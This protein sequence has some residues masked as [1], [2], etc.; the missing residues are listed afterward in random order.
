MKYK[1]AIVKI[2][3]GPDPPKRVD[4]DDW[5][6]ESLD[7]CSC[8]R[9]GTCTTGDN[10]IVTAILNIHKEHRHFSDYTKHLQ[11][12]IMEQFPTTPMVIFMQKGYGDMVAAQHPGGAK[13]KYLCLVEM[14]LE[15]LPE[16]AFVKDW[17][18]TMLDFFNATGR[19]AWPQT[20]VPTYDVLT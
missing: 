10:T 14:D 8:K 5:L 2:V 16:N 18:Q 19:R 12:Y 9:A 7:S 1:P 20:L 15:D 4:L 13:S 3:Q 11:K 17:A 6:A